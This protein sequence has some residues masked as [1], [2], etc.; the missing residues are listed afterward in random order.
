[1]DS[2]ESY[3][4]INDFLSLVL[5]W[6]RLE[7]T[8]RVIRVPLGEVPKI[9]KGA[10]VINLFSSSRDRYRTLFKKLLSKRNSLFCKVL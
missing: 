6:E 7:F 10:V 2:L 5:V 1:M 8:E 4:C 9:R 3:V